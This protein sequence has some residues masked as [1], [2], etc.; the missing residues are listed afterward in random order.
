MEEIKVVVNGVGAAGVA[1]SKIIMAAGVK[2]V[3]GCDQRGALY[4]GRREH[5]N[6]VKDWYARNTH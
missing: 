3:I 2:N 6:W 5:M 1:C 4:E